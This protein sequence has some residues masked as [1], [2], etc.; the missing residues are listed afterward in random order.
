MTH[1]DMEV[2][3]SPPALSDT[4]IHLP[5]LSP[6][7]ASLVALTGPPTA[8]RWS[9]VRTDPGA[10]LLLLRQD[11]TAAASIVA[12]LHAPTLLDAAAHLLDSSEVGYV[13]WARPELLPIR[14]A[15]LAFAHLAEHIANHLQRCCPE[16][17]WMAGLLAPLG[18]L[19]ACAVDPPRTL[20]CLCESPRS[21][22]AAQQ[23]LWGLDQT[24]IARRL[25]QRWLLPR[26]LTAVVGALALPADLARTLDAEPGL[27]QTVQLA[28]TLAQQHGA[29]LGLAVGTPAD[30]LCQS[31]GVDAVEREALRQVAQPFFQE[32]LP[33]ESW[34]DPRALELLPRLLRTTAEQRRQSAEAM[35]DRL[36]SEADRLHAAL[37]DQR[38]GETQRL[39]ERKL[40]ALGELA[41]GAGHEINNPLAVISGQAQYLLNH[42]DDPNRRRALQAIVGQA[43]RIHQTLTDLMQFARPPAPRLQA[44]EVGELMRLVAASL[45][46]LAEQRQVRLVCALPNTVLALQADPAQ[47]RTALMCLVRNA[48]EAAPPEG[49]AAVRV[50]LV[51]EQTLELVVEDNGRGP[52]IVDL[53]HWFDPFYSGRK[54]GRGR[55]L[56]LP[57]AWRLARQHGGDVRYAG[58]A[59]GPTRFVL[60]W[61]RAAW[62]VSAA[63]PVDVAATNGCHVPA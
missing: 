35:L 48:V 40:A 33:P 38:Q 50:E 45:E 5:W 16:R 28:V 53:E 47:V 9:K 12:Q 24:A 22:T 56:G 1:E 7:A 14:R 51:D 41:A 44:V 26:W 21:I 30:E 13:D 63:L 34:R 10:V 32:A 52:S 15:S 39:Q 54:A 8:A 23:R 18:W 3:V 49:W 29:A 36:Q 31:L 4:A 62:A 2:A 59:T 58:T 60:R 42:E 55:G 37:R 43:Q 20:A 19:A 11:E 25:G 46:G 27:F 61:P 17:A 57:T 6:C